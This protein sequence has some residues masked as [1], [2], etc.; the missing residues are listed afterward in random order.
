MVNAH[1]RRNKKNTAVNNHIMKK[2]HDKEAKQEAVEEMTQAL[3]DFILACDIV[4][5]PDREERMRWSDQNFFNLEADKY[6]NREMLVHTKKSREK[7]LSF[8]YPEPH[9]LDQSVIMC[10][11]Q[12][13]MKVHYLIIM[14]LSAQLKD[15]L[16]F[17]LYIKLTHGRMSPEEMLAPL[18][19]VSYFSLLKHLSECCSQYSGL[20]NI[21]AEGLLNFLLVLQ[22]TYRGGLPENVHKMHAMRY[23][24]DKI[25]AVSLNQCG[26]YLKGGRPG[27]GADSHCRGFINPII[28]RTFWKWNGQLKN[29]ESNKMVDKLSSLVPPYPGRRGK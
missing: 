25:A 24:S 22:G 19:R 9:L 17:E 26:I 11:Y 21:R 29:P 13:L 6:R 3:G 18:M 15:E 2:N 23:I 5:G 1:N 12:R 16:L 27:M 10:L 7:T 14:V 20:Q 4:G 28:Y 8:I